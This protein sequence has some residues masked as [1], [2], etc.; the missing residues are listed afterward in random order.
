MDSYGDFSNYGVDPWGA[1]I[2][3]DERPWYDPLLRE[4][5]LR[6]SV[7]SQ[8]VAMK[9][10]LNGP[11][12]RTIY[13]NDLIPPR[14]NISPLAPRKMEATR[15]YNDSFQREV[16]TA[17]YGNGFAFHRESEMFIYWQKNG[18]QLGL[19]AL[20]QSQIGQVVTDHFDILARNE[21][22][23]H[24]YSYMG[25]SDA[26]GFGGID[27]DDRMTTD[28]LDEIWLSL[29]DRQRPY[30]SLPTTYPIGNET[31]CITTAGAV[32][33]LKREGTSSGSPINFIDAHKYTENTPL[34]RGELGMWRGVRF[35]D[36]PMA[37]LWN[38]G[39]IEV[40]TTITAPVKPGAGTPDPRTT[41][42]E[43]TRKVGQ[44]GAVHFIQVAD[45]SGF[46]PN[47]MISIHRV[48]HDA[49]SLA[50]EAN[51]GVLN[52]PVFDDP[53]K[54]DVEIHSVDTVANRITLKEPYMMTGESGEGLEDDL[55]AGVYGYITH[56]ATI[57]T[58]LFLTPG[59]SSSA[60]VAGVAQ[61]PV[62]Y[63]PPP[64]DDYMS[65]FRVSYDFWLKY[66]LWDA[67]A[68]DLAFFRGP[69]VLTGRRQFR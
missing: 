19:M 27:T 47:M 17:R 37:K 30:S 42:V 36:N 69:N 34:I 39:E 11:R 23:R 1:S 40:Q 64:F 58:A 59:L 16:T 26:S 18:A 41:K 33:D 21:Y 53:M 22:L 12:A 14:P 46:E 7:Y 29:R 57:H 48:R 3:L 20:I 50:A 55:G 52:G 67:R 60:L 5:Y 32:H 28:F 63:T 49:D 51:R 56:A 8:H 38:C 9:V 15:L 45:A 65:I 25:M 35:V 31:V 24:P 13:F 2:T 68:Y 10:D 43:G 6:S 54:Q 61:P 4:Q 66:A 44:P 62:I